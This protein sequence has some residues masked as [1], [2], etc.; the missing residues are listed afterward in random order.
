MEFSTII[1][2]FAEEINNIKSELNLEELYCMVFNISYS[3]KEIEFVRKRILLGDVPR[4]LYKYRDVSSAIQFL[5]DQSIYFSNFKEFNDP[6]E[7]SANYIVDFTPQQY[8]DFFI[9]TG[10]NIISAKEVARQI[11]SGKIDGKDVL[12][13][14]TEEA[15]SSIGYFCMTARPDNLLMWAHYAD[16]HRGV[17]LKFD[18]LEDL[19]SF[20]VPVPIEYNSE[21]IDFDTLNSNI[22]ELIRRKSCDWAYEQEYRII[23]PDMHGLMKV[24]RRALKEIIFGCRIKENE[25]ETIMKEGILNGFL[26]LEYSEAKMKCHSYGLSISKI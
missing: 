17:C 13:N 12:R 15:L 10:F 21:Y 8:Y 2:I 25:K 6:F 19:D 3:E 9:S 22:V 23:K 7:S 20:L 4:F 11:A 24:N 16:C 14:A 1:R 18:I 26:D 5:K